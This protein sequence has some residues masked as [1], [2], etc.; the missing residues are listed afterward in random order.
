MRVE[1][2]QGESLTVCLADTDGEFVIKYGK[3][4]LTVKSDLPDSSGREGTIY[5]ENFGD[6]F[7][8]RCGVVA[9]ASGYTQD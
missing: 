1:I 6:S 4:K 3:N 8:K 9:A 7:D 2:K 5:S